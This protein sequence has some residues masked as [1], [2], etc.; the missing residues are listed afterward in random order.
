MLNTAECSFK[1]KISWYIVSA[2]KNGRYSR[3]SIATR[4]WSLNVNVQKDIAADLTIARNSATAQKEN[5]LTPSY[6]IK[7]DKKIMIDLVFKIA[8]FHI[9]CCPQLLS[10]WFRH[11]KKQFD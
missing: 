3:W 8:S 4:S 6:W 11:W 2:V 7:Y 9:S 10:D 1:G 5:L